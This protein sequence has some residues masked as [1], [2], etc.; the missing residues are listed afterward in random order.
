M[1]SGEELEEAVDITEQQRQGPSPQVRGTGELRLVR[2]VPGGT[3]PTGAGSSS[4]PPARRR[5]AWDHPHGCGEQ[6]DRDGVQ[7]PVWG[8]SPR[9]R[10]AVEDPELVVEADG[11]IPTGAGSR[12]LDLRVYGRRGVL[13]ATFM[14]SDK[15]DTRQQLIRRHFQDRPIIIRLEDAVFL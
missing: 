4:R 3:H 9:V 8:P 1:A 5:R 14:D 10:G 11:T 12:L 6:G 15:W 2:V 13:S 7:K